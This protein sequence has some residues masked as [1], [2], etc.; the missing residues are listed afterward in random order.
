LTFFSQMFKQD[1]F[2][3]FRAVTTSEAVIHI[4]Y[5]YSVFPVGTGSWV[6]TPVMLWAFKANL[7][8]SL[9]NSLFQQFDGC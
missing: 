9:S 2:K 4:N 7:V 1:S 3:D 5:Y 8:R 6:Y